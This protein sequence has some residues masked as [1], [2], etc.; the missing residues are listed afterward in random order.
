MTKLI[1]LRES[2]KEK[3]SNDLKIAKKIIYS[4][5]N[6]P[7]PTLIDVI[8]SKIFRLDN[9]SLPGVEAGEV[10]I[11]LGEI[12]FEEVSDD[13]KLK[14]KLKS[15]A[16]TLS[17]YFE[18]VLTKNIGKEK[19]LITLD[20]LDENWIASEIEEYSKILINLINA[21]KYTNYNTRVHNNIKVVPF[22]R[23]DI[24][25]SLNF[26][27]KNKVY[28]D[29]AVEIRWDLDSLDDMFF[30]RI[31]KYKPD[32]LEINV[33]SKSNSAF[34]V[35]FVRHGAP[36]IKHI[37]RRSFMRPRDIIVYFNKINEIHKPSKSGLFT[38]KEL[39]EAE[40]DY[41][42]SMY[43]EIMDE[44]INQKPEIK[45]ILSILQIIGYQT[46]KYKTYEAKYLSTIGDSNS[47]D[48]KESLRFLFR[49]SI[50]GQKI[51]VHWEYFCG[52]PHMTI[53]FD[54]EFY[55]NAALKKRLNITE[56]KA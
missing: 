19:I 55:V 42:N 40:K 4:I 34:D 21:A 50:I 14:S 47:S 44:W 1:F 30:Q 36:P 37:V 24:Y 13:A 43:D 39:Y 6:N 10:N 45:D 2:K 20:Q 27:D 17:Q 26:N 35:K 56:G 9:L 46:F 5:Y 29:N 22:L 11:S 25:D 15:N 32:D 41:S 28:Q 23:T 49:N 33:K 53:D 3:L 8:K 54:K 16:F 7:Q 48:A 18:S 31:L 51:K 12:S 52:N 38:S